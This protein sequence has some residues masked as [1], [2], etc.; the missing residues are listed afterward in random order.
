MVSKCANPRCKAHLKYLH[1]G[2]LYAVPKPL[3]F[4]A[5]VDDSFAAPVG[6]QMECFWLCE[7]CS[8]RM[9]ISH[10]GELILTRAMDMYSAHAT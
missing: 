7:S 9:K 4:C 1:E 8:P 2:S 3:K 5:A 10:T 6:N